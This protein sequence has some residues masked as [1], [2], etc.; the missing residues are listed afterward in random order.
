MNMG[1]N[2]SV[3]FLFA[4]L[5]FAGCATNTNT[6]QNPDEFIH[7]NSDK[8]ITVVSA[9][10]KPDDLAEDGFTFNVSIDLPADQ[11]GYLV[12]IYPASYYPS[13]A[14]YWYKSSTLVFPKSSNIIRGGWLVDSSDFTEVVDTW[15]IVVAIRNSEGSTETI[16]EAEFSYRVEDN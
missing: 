7:Q 15:F 5:L 8:S 11:D 16:Y 2:L 6:N 9:N 13:T 14:A 3:I 1:K 12:W 4:M 10:P